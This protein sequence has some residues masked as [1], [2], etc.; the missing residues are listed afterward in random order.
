[1]RPRGTAHADQQPRGPHARV[2]PCQITVPALVAIG[3]RDERSD[4]D[5]LAALL[6]DA[7]FVRV[8]GGHESAF[9][10]PELAVAMAEFLAER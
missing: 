4:A 10:A 2:T 3:D 6:C 7:R 5:E 8:P 9:T 1:M